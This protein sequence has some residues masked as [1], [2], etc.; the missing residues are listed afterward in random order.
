MSLRVALIVPCFN[1]QPYIAELTSRAAHYI[2]R[3]DMFCVNDGSKDGTLHAIRDAGVRLLSHD[4]N[5]GK[6]QALQTAF[7]VV[8]DEGYDGAVA[9]DADLQHLPEEIPRF[10]DKALGYDVIVGARNY[11]LHNMPLDRWMT[12]K[13]TSHVVSALAGTPITDSQSGFRFLSRDAMDR[14]PL[15]TANYDMES[16]QLI[17]AG[18]MGMRIGEVPIT[19]VYRGEASYIKPWRDTVRFIRMVLRNF[20]WKPEPV[21]REGRGSQKKAG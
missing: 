9:M 2:A 11:D 12:N 8:V 16:E 13:V 19:T 21:G 15:A 7:G 14:V 1:A 4:V 6:G 20:T 10:L 17:R 3:Q 18:R 5:R